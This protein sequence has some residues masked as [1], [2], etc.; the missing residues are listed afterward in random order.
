MIL[1]DVIDVMFLFEAFSDIHIS[2]SKEAK[3][4]LL[5]DIWL[6]PRPGM[7]QMPSTACK[8]AHQ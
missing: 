5:F 8:L 1:V 3:V 6:C 4:Y 2:Q 7:L